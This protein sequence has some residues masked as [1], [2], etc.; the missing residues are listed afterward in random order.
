MSINSSDTRTTE[1]SIK[2]GRVFLRPDNILCIDLKEDYVVEMT[3][4]D[5][6]NNAIGKVANGGKYLVLIVGGK[7]TSFSQEVIENSAA[8]QNFKHTLADAFIINSTHQR[9]LANF[10]VKVV[11]PPVPTRYF[12]RQEEAVEWLQSL[13]KK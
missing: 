12:E 13:F 4:Q 6:I 10:Y 3:D 2:C 8:P 9:L 1:I 5:E 7:Y 11:K